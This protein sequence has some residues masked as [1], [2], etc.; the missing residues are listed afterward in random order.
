MPWPCAYAS[1][2][3]VTIDETSS[4]S[5][6]SRS[7]T[8][9][10]P[11]GPQ[12]PIE[13]TCGPAVSVTATSTPATT[14][15]APSARRLSVRW[16]KAER[17]S[18]RQSPAATPIALSRMTMSSPATTMP[19]PESVTSL[20]AMTAPGASAWMPLSPAPETVFREIVTS[21]RSQST[22]IPMLAGTSP[23]MVTALSVMSAPEPSPS[24]NTPAPPAR[25]SFSSTSGD[26]VASSQIAV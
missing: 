9:T 22:T 26:S 5:D 11:S 19:L 10:M 24:T 23:S 3:R 18:T 15:T 6:E 13:S 17:P 16:A 25:I 2:H 7:A 21:E 1:T 4:S 8:R 14:T 20:P 12:P